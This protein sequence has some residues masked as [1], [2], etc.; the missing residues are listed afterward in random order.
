MRVSI[1]SQTT[2]PV[3]KGLFWYSKVLLLR[4]YYIKSGPRILH[5][6]V[7]QF[8]HFWVSLLKTDSQLLLKPFCMF[9]T[10]RVLLLELHY[11][12]II[13]LHD[14]IWEERRKQ[15]GSQWY[16]I[17]QIEPFIFIHRVVK[18]KAWSFYDFSRCIK[19]E[20]TYMYF[21]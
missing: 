14:V 10:S 15:K 5:P 3:Q 19:H 21:L 6:K 8:L 12:G 7:N 1:E 13:L 2:I 9:L 17:K 18:L 11:T 20:F 16:W 4:L